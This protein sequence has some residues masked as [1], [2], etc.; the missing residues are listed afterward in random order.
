MLLLSS[1]AQSIY[2]LGRYLSRIQFACQVLPFEND[3]TAVQFANAFC[4]PA[5]DANSLN[6]IYMD[7]QQAFSVATQFHQ[8]QNNIQ[9]LRAVLLPHTYSEL[10]QITK[11]KDEKAES[12][13]SVIGRCAEILEG[14]QQQVFLFYSLGHEMEILDQQ[15]RL[16]KVTDAQT[17]KVATILSMLDAN[18]WGS[19]ERSW[20]TF[21]EDQSVSSLYGINDDIAANFEV[22][23]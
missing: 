23:E 17:E 12:I 10:N 20:A 1:A 11:L 15:C 14:E 8:I 13:C 5:W 16:E 22:C 3:Q 4:L 21:L 19:C 18:G 9:Q 6:A 7:P 2:W